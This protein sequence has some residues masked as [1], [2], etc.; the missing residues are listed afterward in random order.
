MYSESYTDVCTAR[1]D[2]LKYAESTGWTLKSS[3]FSVHGSRVYDGGDTDAFAVVTD[4]EYVEFCF[5]S[6]SVG[7]RVLKMNADRDFNEVVDAI[8]ARLT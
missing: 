4:A 8:R 2:L 1:D 5:S 7:I 3:R 6:D